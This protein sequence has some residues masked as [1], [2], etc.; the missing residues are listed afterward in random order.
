MIPKPPRAHVAKPRHIVI[1]HADVV[2]L[3]PPDAE[4]IPTLPPQMKWAGIVLSTK[5][6]QFKTFREPSFPMRVFAF[7]QVGSSA[8]FSEVMCEQ[9]IDGLTIHGS[10]LR[11]Q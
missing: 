5:P 9:M 7:G 2:P 1:S 10:G 6:P 11:T 3:T 8:M 4:R